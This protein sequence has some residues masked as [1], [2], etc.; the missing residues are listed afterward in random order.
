[1]ASSSR[2]N[3]PRVSVFNSFSADIRNSLNLSENSND[4]E[5][6]L[7]RIIKRINVFERQKKDPDLKNIAEEELKKLYKIKSDIIKKIQEEYDYKIF[8]DK[9]TDYVDENT[10]GKKKRKTRKQ[11]KAKRKT[12]RYKRK[13]NRK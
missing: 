3:D 9:L 6:K 11:K 2:R 13:T 5:V 10:G 8:N 7:A 4:Y 1:M 12:R